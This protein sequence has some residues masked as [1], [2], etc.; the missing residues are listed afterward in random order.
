MFISGSIFNQSLWK[1]VEIESTYLRNEIQFFLLIL[2]ILEYLFLL[3]RHI[4]KLGKKG[5]TLY[6]MYQGWKQ[7]LMELWSEEFV[8]KIT[9]SLWWRHQT[10]NGS[11]RSKL[12][13]SFTNVD[14]KMKIKSKRYFEVN[15]SFMKR[16]SQNFEV[17][18][19]HSAVINPKLVRKR[20]ETLSRVLM[21]TYGNL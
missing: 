13:T 6:I 12:V 15:Y 2:Q 19:E 18:A 16:F 10:K 4:D 7:Y 20:V 8:S 5:P 3:W 9:D 21:V 14:R 11:K 17:L 1:L